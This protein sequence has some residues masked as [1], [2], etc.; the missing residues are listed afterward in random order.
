MKKL[1]P[2]ITKENSHLFVDPSIHQPDYVALDQSDD[3][4]SFIKPGRIPNLMNLCAPKGMV[5]SKTIE[6]N[7]KTMAIESVIFGALDKFGDWAIVRI[8]GL[9]IRLAQEGPSVSKLDGNILLA[10]GKPHLTD[11]R[12]GEPVYFEGNV[13][14]NIKAKYYRGSRELT[15][16]NT[17]NF[18][19][20]ETQIYGIKLNLDLIDSKNASDQTFSE[21]KQDNYFR[22]SIRPVIRS[23]NNDSFIED[24]I[25]R[26]HEVSF[27][28]DKAIYK[29]NFLSNFI[30][31]DKEVNLLDICSPDGTKFNSTYE[32]DG[33]TIVI[34]D[35]LFKQKT[36]EQ[37][38]TITE[39]KKVNLS[40]TR[41]SNGQYQIVRPVVV[42]GEQL[43]EPVYGESLNLSKEYE[44]E[45]PVDIT[46]NR[47]TNTLSFGTQEGSDIELI[48]VLFKADLI[49][50]NM[51]A[52]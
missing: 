21:T 46:F 30:K 24:D 23:N 43:V 44:V 8:D 15:W 6:P 10:I 52:A 50:V 17:G 36:G 51:M 32:I 37:T 49:N 11:Y 29:H 9:N 14:A 1:Y 41:I 45:V 42:T 22:S 47:M 28:E 3:F 38:Y 27:I 25:R 31:T 5:V 34:T 12:T 33:S 48:G 40:L 19:N 2:I 13:H 4:T 7:I 35:L 26:C 20:Q 18:F 39:A 16:D